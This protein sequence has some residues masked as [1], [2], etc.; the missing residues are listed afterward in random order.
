MEFEVEFDKN[1]FFSF[2][3]VTC[4]CLM[5][6]PYTAKCT[7]TSCTAHQLSLLCQ[8]L[9]SWHCTKECRSLEGTQGW[10]LACANCLHQAHLS[11][12]SRTSISETIVLPYPF[13]PPPSP[14][15]L[16]GMCS[17]LHLV[18]T[19]S[20]KGTCV[21]SVSPRQE[22]QLESALRLELILHLSSSCPSF[23]EQPRYFSLPARSTSLSTARVVTMAPRLPL[24]PPSQS[25]PLPTPLG[26]SVDEVE[27]FVPAFSASEPFLAALSNTL[28]LRVMV[29]CAML[30]LRLLWGLLCHVRGN[31]KTGRRKD[32][33]TWVLLQSLSCILRSMCGRHRSR[34]SFTGLR[35]V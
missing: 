11:T 22:M 16:W 13:P 1:S 9:W 14:P 32:L 19:L 21:L 24:V 17:K 6:V 35:A 26:W 15:T 27:R 25:T 20:R 29:N 5:S 34:G 7:S 12:R 30:W 23:P 8:S 3:S 2:A 31:A 28:V 10:P 33:L 4:S 18:S